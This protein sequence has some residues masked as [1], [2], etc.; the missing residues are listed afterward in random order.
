ML[1]KNALEQLK[2]GI[3]MRRSSWNDNEGYL[4]ILPD[5]DFVWKIVT[6]PTPNAGNF[7]FSIADFEGVDWVKYEQPVKEEENAGEE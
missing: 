6:R 5:M 1:F 4:K 2:S 3:A 7:I